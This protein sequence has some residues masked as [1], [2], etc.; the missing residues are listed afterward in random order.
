[1]LGAP[2]ETTRAFS[3]VPLFQVGTRRQ[4]PCRTGLQCSR[5]ATT[6]TPFLSVILVAGRAS[7]VAHSWDG[8]GSVRTDCLGS[9]A[10]VRT[11]KSLSCCRDPGT[12][13][14]L[15]CGRRPHAG[16]FPSQPSPPG[17]TLLLPFHPQVWFCSV[18]LSRLS[19]VR[20]QLCASVCL[21]TFN[22]AL[23]SFSTGLAVGPEGCSHPSP[24]PPSLE[25]LG[26]VVVE[27]LAPSSES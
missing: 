27:F 17:E 15:R 2:L 23:I 25:S 24:H 3:P 19:N 10:S 12:R 13:A 14:A 20:A 7:M 16:L 1:M 18:L 5:A 26:L 8:L 4:A 6:L 21:L 11:I 22:V 9:E